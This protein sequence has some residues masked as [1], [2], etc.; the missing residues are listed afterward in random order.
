M[1]CLWVNRIIELNIEIMVFKSF[2]I[3]Y[4]FYKGYVEVVN[5]TLKCRLNEIGCVYFIWYKGV[6]YKY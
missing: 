2:F 5:V 4:Y 3:R 6:F 1:K